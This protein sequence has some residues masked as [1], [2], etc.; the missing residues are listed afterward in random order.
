MNILYGWLGLV[1]GISINGGSTNGLLNT[2]NLIPGTNITI[3]AVNDSANN[4]VNVTI[5]GAALGGEDPFPKILMMM[6]G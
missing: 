3:T 5:G 1:S 4:K 2:I 6:G